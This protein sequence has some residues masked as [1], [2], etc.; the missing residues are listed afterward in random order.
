MRA[1]SLVEIALWDVKGQAAGLPVWA[2]LGG[3]R[4]EAE[5]MMV[6]GYARPGVAPE[7]LGQIVA[8]YAADGYRRVKIARAPDPAVTTAVVRAAAD[9]LPPVGELVVDAAWALRDAEHLRRETAGWGDAPI[10]WLEDPMPPE[11]VAACA[12]LARG[13]A[14][15]IGWGDEVTD[16]HVL[17]RLAE[18]DCLDV[19]R[20]DATAVGGFAVAA[21]LAGF[22]TGLGLP[23]SF[24][25][26][27]ELHVHLA[28][29]LPGQLSIETFDPVDNPF[30]P[31]ATLLTGGPSIAKGVARAADAPGLGLAFDDERIRALAV[32]G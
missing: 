27:P 26:Y 30:D 1:I 3:A 31:C 24:H 22:A 14:L 20:I 32:V 16:E 11:N 2:L 4:T 5:V 23:V 13:R 28:L 8:D 9:R 7:E 15:P 12:R 10:A 6:G 25:V 18:A 29:G 21:R 17:R 19:L